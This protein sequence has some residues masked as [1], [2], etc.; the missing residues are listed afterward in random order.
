MDMRI[1]QFMRTYFEL[2]ESFSSESG[3]QYIV[4][5]HNKKRYTVSMR[6][7]LMLT[8]E[9]VIILACIDV[10]HML[11]ALQLIVTGH[12]VPMTELTEK[13]KL[14]VSNNK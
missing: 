10:I 13:V 4:A 8:Q 2:L 1:V 7:N 11:S 14:L 3:T 6:G 12:D 9:G 5:Y